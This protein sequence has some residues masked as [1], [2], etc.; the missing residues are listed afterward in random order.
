MSEFAGYALD[1]VIEAENDRLAYRDGVM[2][3]EEAF[4]LGIIDHFGAEDMTAWSEIA[5]RPQG[6]IVNRART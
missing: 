5:G 1:E 4:D 6:W 2:S 3:D